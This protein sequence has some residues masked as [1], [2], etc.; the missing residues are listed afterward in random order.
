MDFTGMG[1]RKRAFSVPALFCVSIPGCCVYLYLCSCPCP[2]RPDE[3]R[4]CRDLTSGASVWELCDRTG[5][6]GFAANVWPTSG[7]FS[8]QFI[9]LG[10]SETLSKEKNWKITVR[11][12]VSPW[13]LRRA[14]SLPAACRHF[15]PAGGCPGPR[16]FPSKTPQIPLIP[17]AG[18]T[19]DPNRARRCPAGGPR[20]PPVNFSPH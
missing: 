15:L 1:N 6:V 16:L 4:G 9:F 18:L 8:L 2:A 5:D 13:A 3:H 17:R 10:G 7:S 20:V 19:R 11:C 12:T 14:R